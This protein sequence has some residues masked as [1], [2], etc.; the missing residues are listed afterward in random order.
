MSAQEDEALRK[1][2][3]GT[4]KFLYSES[5]ADDGEITRGFGDHPR[6]FMVYTDDGVTPMEGQ[7]GERVSEDQARAD[8]VVEDGR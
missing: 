1:R 5:Y 3:V 7:M 6:G 2:V 8:V 4:W